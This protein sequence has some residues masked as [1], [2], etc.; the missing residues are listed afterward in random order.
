VEGQLPT[1]RYSVH[2]TALTLALSNG[3]TLKIITGLWNYSEGPVKAAIEISGG[4][5]KLVCTTLA[6]IILQAS[7]TEFVTTA[8]EKQRTGGRVS[9]PLTRTQRMG[10]PE[11]SA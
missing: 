8:E 9:H 6:Q 2:P 7:S 10:Q 1:T 4:E 3:W 5:K 11:L